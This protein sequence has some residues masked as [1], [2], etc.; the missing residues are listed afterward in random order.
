V[1]A[2]LVDRVEAGSSLERAAQAVGVTSR[3]LRRWRRAA[4]ST[5]PEDRGCVELEQRLLFALGRAQAA[6]RKPEPEP[7]EA[8]ADV[9]ARDYPDRWGPPLVDDDWLDSGLEAD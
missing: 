2:A 9:L 6:Q 7:W 1:A 3:T 8:A 5:R 4:W